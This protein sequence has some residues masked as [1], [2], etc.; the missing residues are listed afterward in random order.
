MSGHSLPFDMRKLLGHFRWPLPAENAR[1]SKYPCVFCNDQSRHMSIDFI[2]DTFLCYRCGS[3]GG[4]L[5]L[6]RQ[7]YGTS[8]DNRET[9]ELIKQKLGLLTGYSSAAPPAVSERMQITCRDED[10]P[11]TSRSDEELDRVY[12][13]FLDE[14]S[15][16]H[17]HKAS[18]IARGLT[19]SEIIQDG[20]KT[21]PRGDYQGIAAKLLAKGLTLD[22]VPGFFTV[23]RTGKWSV[24]IPA[25]G[26]FVPIRN[27]SGQITGMQIR[28]DR[29]IKGCKYVWLSSNRFRG[30]RLLNG[31][32]VRVELHY[33]GNFQGGILG[34]TEGGLKANVTHH[35]YHRLPGITQDLSLIAYQGVGAL[36]NLESV[37]GKLSGCGFSH[38]MEMNDR[39]KLENDGVRVAT[40]RLYS[41][42]DNALRRWPQ[43]PDCMSMHPDQYLGKGID[44]HILAI[45]K[46]GDGA[47]RLTSG[48]KP[49]WISLPPGKANPQ[50]GEYT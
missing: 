35:L 28:L 32:K 3:H 23:K 43:Q 6:F 45:I 34:L 30:Y 50:E 9:T 7:V 49:N 31:T 16:S 8:M 17:N 27:L 25:D 47:G 40:G 21:A 48:I 12:R 37:V 19:Q 10:N 4:M 1:R 24:F 38:I 33:V 5:D 22:S 26:F 29:P 13:A 39:D 42:V 14:L 36:A 41:M 2:N 18:L 20:Y 44:D 46:N 11:T 15:L